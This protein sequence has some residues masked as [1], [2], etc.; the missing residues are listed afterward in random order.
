[1]C[2]NCRCFKAKL[3]CS[4]NCK[5]KDCENTENN[6]AEVHSRYNVYL[7]RKSPGVAKP[8]YLLRKGGQ[9]MTGAATKLLA[10][11]V[12]ALLLT[13]ASAGRTGALAGDSPVKVAFSSLPAESTVS[14]GWPCLLWPLSVALS[15]I[16]E[17]GLCVTS[18]MCRRPSQMHRRRRFDNSIDR[19]SAENLLCPGHPSE[20]RLALNC[21]TAWMNAI[22][23]L[24]HSHFQLKRVA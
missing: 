1:M 14:V 19:F 23:L 21:P 17:S 3:L 12:L 15:H 13:T 24:T 20:Y 6:K 18:V 16:P 11:A 10:A 7:K 9:E 5:C 4:E 22:V 2:S 8:R